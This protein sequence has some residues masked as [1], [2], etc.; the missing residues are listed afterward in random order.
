MRRAVIL[1][2]A[3]LAC[4]AP[5]AC[6][7]TN[8]ARPADRDPAAV[9]R[10]FPQETLFVVTA[11]IGRI[12]AA[13]ITAKLGALKVVY[14]S[15][16]SDIDAL[17]AVI[18]LDPW[19]QFDS[20]TIGGMSL[21][22]GTAIVFRGRAIDEARVTAN[23]RARLAND[24]DELISRR[25]GKRTVW[26]TRKRPETA[27]VF[28]DGGT[29][30]LASNAWVER[31][32]DLADGA[33]AEPSAASNPS[34]V[35]AW[36]ELSASALWGA[37]VLP[38]EARDYL[39]GDFRLRSLGTMRRVTV[40]VDLTDAL[41]AKLAIDFGDVAQA[42][43]LAEDLATL[44]ARERRAKRDAPAYQALFKGLTEYADGPTFR[45]EL[46]LSKDAAVQFA[47]AMAVGSNVAK[48]PSELPAPSARAL[49]LKRDWLAP[50]PTDVTLSDVRSYDAWDRRTHAL[51]EVVN[52][53]DKP[54]VPEIVIRYRDGDDKKLDE[55]HCR[56]PTIVLL[57]HE[58]IGCDPGVPP[59]AAT[60]IYTIRTAPAERAAAFAAKSRVT[61]KVAG[62]R[63]ER[64]S[65]AVLW[66]EGQVKNT[67][68]A[69]VRD[70]R[71]H[72]TFYDG[73]QKIVGYGDIIAAANLA[74]G[75]SATFRLQSGPL[76]APAKSF[77][78]I[79]FSL[80]VPR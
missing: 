16:A 3:V 63:L 4:V 28:L 21:Q 19:T 71:V 6:R 20:V 43:D 70:A 8:N 39:E 34:L 54:V 9:L 73:E 1:A 14:A 13:P 38:R 79:G 69:I 18:G 78:A 22:G 29:L 50:P 23:A 51:F 27:A 17:A 30:V 61:L 10:L 72:A 5:G 53:S 68:A 12:R 47:E 77:T 74:P 62:A 44:L 67:T 32:V 40:A 52:R 76:F 37:G 55:R 56:V 59:A 65:G 48:P 25:Y 57:A 80:I 66:L 24:G 33:G 26:T 36:G 41:D 45:A 31:I 49:T 60:A 75:A 2:A 35:A 42:E 58:R 64:T 15:V 46:R 7:R 11:D